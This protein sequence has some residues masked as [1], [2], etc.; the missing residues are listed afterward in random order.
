METTEN[1]A[2]SLFLFQG[3]ENKLT[4]NVNNCVSQYT[5]QV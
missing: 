4:L 2:L 5:I 1:V 3:R